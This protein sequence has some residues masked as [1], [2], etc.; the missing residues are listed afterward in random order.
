M[1]ARG[2]EW[3]YR[4]ELVLALLGAFLALRS[5]HS[6]AAAGLCLAIIVAI[7]LLQSAFYVQGRHRFLIEPLL[8]IFTAIGVGA[9][10]WTQKRPGPTETSPLPVSTAIFT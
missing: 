5:P 6:R 9:G 7:S 3:I 10:R 2:Y 4:V 1:A 8:L